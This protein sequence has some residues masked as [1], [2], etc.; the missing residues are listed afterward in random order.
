M[1]VVIAGINSVKG[2]KRKGKRINQPIAA[3]KGN[4]VIRLKKRRK[5]R[6]KLKEK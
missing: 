5:E 3:I 4:P 2:R 6:S 1:H